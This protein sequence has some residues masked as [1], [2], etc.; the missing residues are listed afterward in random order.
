MAKSC[1]KFCLGHV[2][3]HVPHQCLVC[4]G[5]FPLPP[6]VALIIGS[7]GGGAGD[8]APAARA[9]ELPGGAGGRADWEV[10]GGLQGDGGGERPP[11]AAPA[12]VVEDAGGLAPRAGLLQ[13]R[14]EGH[15]RHVCL[16]SA[17][18]SDWCFVI[19]FFVS[20]H[21][22]VVLIFVRFFFAHVPA[23]SAHK[24]SSGVP[25]R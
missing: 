17:L 23:L 8:G 3:A 9:P 20:C 4:F 12:R 6:A 14:E 15:L 18:S 21:F 25:A 13:A 10:V 5:S 16:S 7:D 11:E 1:L 19:L 24:A 22:L 2:L